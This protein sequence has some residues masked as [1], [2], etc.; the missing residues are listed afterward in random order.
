MRNPIAKSMIA[1]VLLATAGAFAMPAVA[2][3]APA[4]NAQLVSTANVL[5][6]AELEKRASAQIPD[7]REIEVEGLLAEVEGYDAQ[8]RKVKLV[9]DRRSGAVLSHKIKY[10]K[11]ADRTRD[12]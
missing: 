11:H 7:I 5:S 10:S 4:P 3:Q 9:M 2:Q 1:T 8:G 12:R 6:M